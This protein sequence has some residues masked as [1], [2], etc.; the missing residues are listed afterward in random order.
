MFHKSSYE[1]TL[2]ETFGDWWIGVVDSLD[3]FLRA[4]ASILVH[5]RGYKTKKKSVKNSEIDFF[6]N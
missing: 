4:K 2:I 1:H 5:L 6:L 3:L